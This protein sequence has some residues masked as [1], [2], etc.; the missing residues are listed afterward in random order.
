MAHK[1]AG[2][3]SRNGRDTAGR[4]LGVKKFGGETVIAGN[5]IIRQRGTKWHPGHRRRPRRR[6]HDLRDS[7]TAPWPSKPEPTGKVFVSVN[8]AAR[9]PNNP[10]G[11]KP[12]GDHQGPPADASKSKGDRSAGSPFCCWRASNML[13]IDPRSVL[14]HKIET[15]RLVLRAPIRGDVPQ[16]VK[17]ADNK[18]IAEMLRRLPSPYTR[19]DAI[20]FV[21]IFAQREDEQALCDHARRQPDRRRRLHLLRRTRR[22]SS[23]TGWASRTGARAYATEAGRGA[24]RGGARHRAVSARS[25]PGR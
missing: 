21:E 18:N 1:K 2:G 13:R 19:A 5:I 9:P 11:H 16:L 10:V 24:D 23:A 22:P 17:L 8:P 4:R 20:G 3:S 12:A 14:P 15:E 6:S 7:S 25:A